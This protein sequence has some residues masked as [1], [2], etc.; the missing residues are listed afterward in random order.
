MALPTDYTAGQSGHVAAHEQVNTEVNRVALIADALPSNLAKFIRD[1]IADTLAQGANVTITR[2]GAGNTITIAATGGSGGGGGDVDASQ[3]VSGVIAPARLGTGSRDGTKVLRDDGVWS[4]P[5]G[6]ALLL[7]VPASGTWLVPLVRNASQAGWDQ[8]RTGCP[9]VLAAPTPIDA[10][11]CFVTVSAAG[12]SVRLS[13]YD[14]DSYGRARN[15]VASVVVSGAATGAIEGAITP[16]TL[17]AGI[18]HPAIQSS[19]GSVQII[20]GTPANHL[21]AY[22]SSNFALQGNG[23]Y[24]LFGSCGTYGSPKTAI[25]SWGSGMPDRVAFLAIHTP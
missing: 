16:V 17:P 5:G 25:D 14:S 20:G 3:I 15:R 13:L 12:S 7:P 24:M 8:D 10:L 1:T 18:Y 19:D 23:N 22:T 6:A 4:A 9:L 11:A 21:G 2:D